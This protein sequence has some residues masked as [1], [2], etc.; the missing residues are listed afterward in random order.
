M[1]QLPYR[2][3]R[4][5]RKT[6]SIEIN[7]EA[8]LVVRAPMRMPQARIDAFLLEKQDWIAQHMQRQIQRRAAHPEPDEARWAEL[9]RQAK[10][11]LPGRVE[12]YARQMGLFPTA[13][14]F[15]R[16][17]TRFGSC[18]AK[19]SITF[20]LRL[21]EYPPAA[22]DYVVVHELAHIRHKNHGKEFYR[23][24]ASVLPDYRQREALL[25]Q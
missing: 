15:S 8:Q 22:I 13:V 12:F 3:I 1:S 4:S 16:A 21:M 2:L 17:K 14:R 18:S 7:R 9:L 24:V 19:D 6:L 10:D 25:K 11:Y 20:S 23:L 5:R